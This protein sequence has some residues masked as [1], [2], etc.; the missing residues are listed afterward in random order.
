MK[1]NIKAGDKFTIDTASFDSCYAPIYRD[2]TRGVIYECSASGLDADPK[3]P[4]E[5]DVT[6]FDDTNERVLTRFDQ[7]TKV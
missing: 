6:F 3:D 5:I 7:V 4:G 2:C 1:N